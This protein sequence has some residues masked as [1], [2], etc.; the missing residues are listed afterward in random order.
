MHIHTQAAFVF[1]H[2]LTSLSSL[3]GL[4]VSRRRSGW[5]GGRF[6]GGLVQTSNR[7]SCPWVLLA[8]IGRNVTLGSVRLFTALWRALRSQSEVTLLSSRRHSDGSLAGRKWSV[9]V[10]S[11]GMVAGGS[12]WLF[13]ALWQALRS[14]S[15]V[16]LLSSRRRFDDSLAGRNGRSECHHME[17]YVLL[18]PWLISNCFQ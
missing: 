2:Y 1:S 11:Y 3:A 6:L 8:G 9:G 10:S 18:A 12:V 15:K 13:T 14:Q 16:T 4:A 17:R 5:T 7:Q